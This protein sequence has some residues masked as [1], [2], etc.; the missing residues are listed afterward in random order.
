MCPTAIFTSS[1][2]EAI[3]A[4]LAIR[5]AGLRVPDDI[6]LVSFDGTAETEFTHPRLTTVRQPTE[7]LAAAAVAAALSTGSGD[8]GPEVIA[9]E[10]IVR[11]SCGCTAEAV[12]LTP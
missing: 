1:D 4:L 2:F 10:L 3:G 6:A 9:P 8:A 7:K 11:E 12:A 5:S